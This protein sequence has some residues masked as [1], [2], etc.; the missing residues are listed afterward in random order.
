MCS[1]DLADAVLPIIDTITS[2]GT[3]AVFLLNTKGGTYE[4]R[5]YPDRGKMADK[6][7]LD[8]SGEVIAVGVYDAAVNATRL[9]EDILA[10]TPQ[11][12]LGRQGT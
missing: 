3:R 8:Q 9:Y 4:V 2:R 7:L 11:D 5:N 1:S 12:I 10:A 6:Y